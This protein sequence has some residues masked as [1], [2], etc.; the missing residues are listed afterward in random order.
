MDV[1][2]NFIHTMKCYSATK[3]NYHTMKRHGRTLEAYYEVK[4]ANLKKLHAV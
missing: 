4:E 1:Y 3:I 2:S